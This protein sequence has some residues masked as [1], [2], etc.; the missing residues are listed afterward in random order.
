MAFTVVSAILLPG[1]SSRHNPYGA[2]NITLINDEYDNLRQLK[3][4]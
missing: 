2:T 1:L 3:T 4:S